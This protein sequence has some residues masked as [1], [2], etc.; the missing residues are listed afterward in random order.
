MALW[1]RAL[2]PD[3]ILCVKSKF[4]KVDYYSI[5]SLSVFGLSPEETFLYCGEVNTAEYAVLDYRR[6]Y[7]ARMDF[8]KCLGDKVSVETVV[9]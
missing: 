8:E 6:C 1:T 5:H 2:V 4:R 7:R 9:L 3:V